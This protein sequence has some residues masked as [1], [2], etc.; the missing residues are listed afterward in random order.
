MPN[1]NTLLDGIEPNP[2]RYLQGTGRA[3][4]RMANRLSN[5]LTA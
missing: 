2:A 5:F 3:G 1:G 4:R